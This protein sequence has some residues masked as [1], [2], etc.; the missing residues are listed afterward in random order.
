MTLFARFKYI[1]NRGEAQYTGYV[2]EHNRSLLEMSAKSTTHICNLADARSCVDTLNRLSYNTMIFIKAPYSNFTVS[3]YTER[4][5]PSND[6]KSENDRT[7][8][9]K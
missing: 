6:I 9:K 5:L 8:F 4:A 3:Q 2:M 7:T 1:N